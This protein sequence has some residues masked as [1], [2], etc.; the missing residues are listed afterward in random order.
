MREVWVGLHNVLHATQPSPPLFSLR[1]YSRAVH[2]AQFIFL[3]VELA[4]L[5]A[6]VDVFRRG[7]QRGKF[8]VAILDG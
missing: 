5:Q 6:V 1:R 2:H 3:S 8:S 4:C 7:I